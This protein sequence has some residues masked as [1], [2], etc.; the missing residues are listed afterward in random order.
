M[1]DFGVDMIMIL[2][3]KYEVEKGSCIFVVLFFNKYFL[4]KKRLN[5]NIFS[6]FKFK[7][8]KYE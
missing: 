5:L 2:I 4:E 8:I 3:I 1:F 6:V 7:N